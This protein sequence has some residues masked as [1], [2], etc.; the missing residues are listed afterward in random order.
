MMVFFF[1]GC[2]ATVL[3]LILSGALPTHTSVGRM[4]RHVVGPR[5]ERHS[6]CLDPNLI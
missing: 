3:D 2:P 1:L 5:L 4:G 6:R